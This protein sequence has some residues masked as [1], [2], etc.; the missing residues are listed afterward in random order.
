MNIRD[1]VT[2]IKGSPKT[3][4]LAPTTAVVHQVP[5]ARPTAKVV[6]PTATPTRAPTSKIVA[7]SFRPSFRPS[8][9]PTTR[10]TAKP[11]VRCVGFIFLF[12]PLWWLSLLL[13]QKHSITGLDSSSSSIPT[14]LLTYLM[15]HNI[16]VSVGVSSSSV[17][18]DDT[19]Y[20]NALKRC[21]SLGS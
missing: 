13:A 12:N 1:V 3:P 18:T 20:Y 9:R 16:G 2:E 17:S 8:A 4:T 5:T 10:V 6:V 19:D 15:D 14:D 11:T 21:V 7:P